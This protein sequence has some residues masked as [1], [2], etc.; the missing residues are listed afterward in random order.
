M[1]AYLYNVAASF[2]FISLAIIGILGLFLNRLV[3]KKL[4]SIVGF[5]RNVA[6]EKR[7]EKRIPVHGDDEIAILAVSI[8]DMLEQIELKDRQKDEA[9]LKL[10][11]SETYLKSIFDACPDAIFILDSESWKI[12]DVND[13]A[14]AIYGGRRLDFLGRD[15]AAFSNPEVE[16]V[17]Q[18]LDKTRREGPQRFEQQT[19]RLDGSLFWAA[20]HVNFSLIGGESRFI[21]MTRDVSRRKQAEEDREKLQ[22]QLLQAQKM[23][24]VGTLAGGVAH[25]FNNLLQAMSGN[26]Q[27]LQ[28][29]RHGDS[30]EAKRLNTV[31]RS[32][33]RATRLVRQL[34]LFSRKAVVKRE[35]IDLNQIVTESV[36]MLERTIPRMIHV[37]VHL[38]ADLW[39]IEADP[40]QVEQ[41]LLNLGSNAADA[42]PDGGRLAFQTENVDLTA[43][44]ARTH[45]DAEPGPYVLLCVT[46]TGCGMDKGTMD[47]IF[48]PFFTTKEVGRGTGLGLATVYGIIKN[49]GGSVLCYSEPS[50]GTI[51]RIYWPAALDQTTAAVHE[52]EPDFQRGPAV[53]EPSGGLETILVV[54]DEADIL[55]LT[56]EALQSL[57]YAV[58]TASSGEE[59]LALYAENKAGVDLIVLDLGMPGM[60]GRQCLRELVRLDSRV[61]VLIASGYA[62]ASL[63]D[64]VRSDGAADFIA[65]P[66]QLADLVIRVREILETTNRS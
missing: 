39:P 56:A 38:A 17:G 31:S 7:Y 65:K 55:E 13:S 11:R 34:L 40:V 29:N 48:D 47:Q 41:V 6:V 8:N 46:D 64:E 20:F 63:S 35:R 43:D 66:Y 15:F 45:L 2:L 14:V 18:W 4:F 24:A 27:L 57:G 22:A 54:D 36:A 44:F 5:A 3:I 61:R 16:A 25:D 42:M 49:H 23:E 19:R 62:A 50:Q 12:S 51:F 9:G 37:E 21:V 53:R 30:P 32:I 52:P 58:L 60:G 33:E 28:W 10:S 59:A 1:N 26:I